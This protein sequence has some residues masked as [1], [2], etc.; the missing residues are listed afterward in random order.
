MNSYRKW[1]ITCLVGIFSWP[2]F[3]HVSA[4][5]KVGFTG[6]WTHNSIT[7][8]TGYFYDLRYNPDG[9]MSFSVPVQYH[10]NSWLAVGIDVA[11]MQ[12][13]YK[14]ERSGFY[15]A[16]GED[17][18]GHYLDLPVYAHFSFGGE[19]LR[20]FLNAGMYLGAWLS[21]HRK[22]ATFVWMPTGM[23]NVGAVTD[24]SDIYYLWNYNE[25]YVFDTRRDNRFDAGALA[26]VGISWQ[27]FPHIELLAEARYYYAL[28]DQ[29]K[30]YMIALV[31][32]YHNTLTIQ[33]GVLFTLGKNNK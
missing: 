6:G 9:G 23:D 29:Q 1:I 17:I 5:W 28:T 11:Y 10:F 24:I 7:T 22:G 3:C 18:S 16:L 14:K 31:P 27:L 12:K 30:R 33:A 20:G 19:R 8:E 25:K 21:S 15:H 13:N 26:G 4:Q 2:G 32:R